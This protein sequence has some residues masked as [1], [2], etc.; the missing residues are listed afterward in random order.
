[1]ANMDIIVTMATIIQE[2]KI[3]IRPISILILSLSLIFPLSAC[4]KTPTIVSTESN[5][6]LE[7][8]VNEESIRRMEITLNG[9][10]YIYNDHLTNVVFMGV[11]NESIPETVVGTTSAGQADAIYLVSYDRVTGNTNIISIPRD[12]IT[13]VDVFDRDGKPLGPSTLQ[14]CLSY[15]FG[16]GKHESCRNTKEAVYRLFY[17]LPIQNYCSLTLESMKKIASL[18]GVISVTLPNDSLA[19]LDPTLT[20]GTRV[21]VTSDN[22][23]IF[24]RYRDTSLSHSAIE[25]SERHQAYI[26]ALED[27]YLSK[28]YE[29]SE[30]VV[31]FYTQLEPYMITNMHSDDFVQIV[32]CLG[33]NTFVN[34]WTIPGETVS[35]N[36]YDEFY[37][38]ED[39]LYEQIISC[40]FK[41]VTSE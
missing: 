12:T 34:I 18:C 3:K 25:R 30:R 22:A 20:T 9:K 6:Q 28:L 7:G 27:Q 35:T 14:I 23:E 10:E 40:F 11:D 15:A 38:N 36:Q 31:D 2:S 1:M 24:F 8:D 29:D 13:T 33:D 4:S 19:K 16:D 37:V 41:E 39:L 21:E 26:K 5:V 17:R 32:E